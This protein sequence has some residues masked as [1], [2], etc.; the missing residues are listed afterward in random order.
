MWPPAA[1]CHTIP[2]RPPLPVA[3]SN[4]VEHHHCM[5]RLP[6][7]IPVLA[8]CTACSESRTAYNE[9]RYAPTSLAEANG[10]VEYLTRTSPP[11]TYELP[12]RAPAKDGES[13]ERIPG[14][15]PGPQFKPTSMVAWGDQPVKSGHAIDNEPLVGTSLD[16]PA[17]SNRS[18]DNPTLHGMDTRPDADPALTAPRH[19]PATGMTD[20]R[21]RPV[22]AS[23]AAEAQPLVGYND[24]YNPYYARPDAI[25]VMPVDNHDDE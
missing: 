17:G 12:D 5:S 4:A 22:A 6:L 24:N 7:L 13:H 18:S 19:L 16:R 8:L 2:P 9:S 1:L 10:P 11:Q 3:R 21:P 15:R 20:T 14:A 23:D 25:G